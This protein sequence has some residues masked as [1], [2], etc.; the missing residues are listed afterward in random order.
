MR[1]T[2]VADD[3]SDDFFRFLNLVTPEAHSIL[4]PNNR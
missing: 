1:P 2:T 4:G 3:K